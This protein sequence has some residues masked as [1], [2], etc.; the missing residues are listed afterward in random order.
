M[1]T[2]V[3]ETL[4]TCQI[5]SSVWV[6]NEKCQ[7]MQ[8]ITPKQ[9]PAPNTM[10]SAIICLLLVVSLAPFLCDS[11]QHNHPENLWYKPLPSSSIADFCPPEIGSLTWGWISPDLHFWNAWIGWSTLRGLF[12]QKMYITKFMAVYASMMI[13]R[14]V[15]GRCLMACEMHCITKPQYLEQDEG[16]SKQV[17]LSPVLDFHFGQHEEWFVTVTHPKIACL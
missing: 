1:G 12:H 3:I 9:I 4:D 7:A 16:F 2:A 15:T 5:N 14:W 17:T 8:L 13:S 10:A 6:G 11:S